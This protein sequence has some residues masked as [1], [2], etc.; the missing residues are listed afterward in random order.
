MDCRV[1]SAPL[2]CLLEVSAG[3]TSA[4]IALGFQGYAQ[5]TGS[6]WFMGSV[7]SIAE[8]VSNSE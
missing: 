8:S 2:V 3:R 6:L 4:M 1:L 5:L 7:D